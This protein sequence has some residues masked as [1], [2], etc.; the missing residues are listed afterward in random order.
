MPQPLQSH[1]RWRGSA[2]GGFRERGMRWPRPKSIAATD[3]RHASA[4]AHGVACGQSGTGSTSILELP[5]H[6]S[7]T[8][9]DASDPNTCFT[10]C[11]WAGAR[12]H[13]FADGSLSDVPRETLDQAM[14]PILSWRR[15]P[16]SENH[17]GLSVGGV[18]ARLSDGRRG[19]CSRCCR[20]S[21]SGWARGA[22]RS[23]TRVGTDREP[24]N[25]AVRGNQPRCARDRS[26][27]PSKRQAST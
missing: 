1:V 23:R 12:I 7:D 14:T 24:A 26:K 6:P 9:A 16:T 11:S 3:Q 22:G 2:C 4:R 20:S 18:A 19:P 13:G 25:T 8:P 10:V 27:L 17:R 15:L 21:C 5:L